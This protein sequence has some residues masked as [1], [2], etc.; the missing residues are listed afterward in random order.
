MFSYLQLLYIRIQKLNSELGMHLTFI[1]FFFS[2]FHQRLWKSGRLWTLCVKYYCFSNNC[3]SNVDI[4][5]LFITDTVYL[6]NKLLIHVH[7][8]NDKAEISSA[9]PIKFL[10][11]APFQTDLEIRLWRPLLVRTTIASI[12]LLIEWTNWWRI[13]IGWNRSWKKKDQ[14]KDVLLYDSFTG[15]LLIYSNACY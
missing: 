1:S 7:S 3:S 12:S 13:A 2:Y 4:I 14:N 9:D 11:R 15:M 10:S 5:F 8:C 6:K